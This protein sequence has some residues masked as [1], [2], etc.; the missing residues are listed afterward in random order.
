LNVVSTGKQKLNLLRALNSQI[1]NNFI[2]HQVTSVE[3]LCDVC[4]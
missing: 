3:L 2:E 4:D 1:P